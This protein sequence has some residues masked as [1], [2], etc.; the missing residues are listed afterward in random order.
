[1]ADD[2]PAPEIWM[3]LRFSPPIAFSEA[4]RTARASCADAGTDS[5]TARTNITNLFT[6][7][8]PESAFAHSATA[9]RPP[10]SVPWPYNPRNPGPRRRHARKHKGHEEFSGDSR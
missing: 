7:S 1:M 10:G 3:V 6:I 5:P 8:P 2:H 4:C 9:D